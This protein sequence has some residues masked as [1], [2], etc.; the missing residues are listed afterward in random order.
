MK[1]ATNTE[2][3]AS[4]EATTTLSSPSMT[5]LAGASF[6]NSESSTSDTGTSTSMMLQL[7]Q[8]A[9]GVPG[10]TVAPGE[11]IR[12]HTMAPGGAEIGWRWACS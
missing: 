8:L 5:T 1:M 3:T 2:P 4:A 12:L 9:T 10:C 11:A 6:R 7:I